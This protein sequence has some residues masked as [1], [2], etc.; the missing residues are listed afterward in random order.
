MLSFKTII[1]NSLFILFNL[2]ICEFEVTLILLRACAHPWV[3]DVLH[4]RVNFLGH[5]PGELGLNL[6]ES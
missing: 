5:S 2:N 4:S 6:A 1:G 3:W